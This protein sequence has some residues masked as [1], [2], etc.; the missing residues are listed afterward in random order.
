MNKYEALETYV[1]EL[2]EMDDEPMLGEDKKPVTV[3]LYG[4]GSKTYLNASRDNSNA[5]FKKLARKG[6]FETTAEETE[7]NHLELMIKCTKEV[8]SNFAAC[9]PEFTDGLTGADMLRSVY[10]APTLRYILERLTE[11]QKNWAN[12]KPKPTTN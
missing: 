12:F 6:K 8:S 9:F 2:L 10:S 4:P 7:R 3:T 5:T 1:C 11:Q